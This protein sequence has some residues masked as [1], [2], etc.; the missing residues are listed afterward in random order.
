[1]RWHRFA[2]LYFAIPLFMSV[3]LA[4][5]GSAYAPRNNAVGAFMLVATFCLPYYWMNAGFTYSAL[6]LLRRVGWP[7]YLALVFG[8]AAGT[9]AGYFYFVGYINMMSDVF[10][11]LKN[12]LSPDRT[13]L[14][15]GFASYISGPPGYIYVPIWVALHAAYESA[16][17]DWIFFPQFCQQD[18][19]VGKQD[20]LPAGLPLFLVRVPS[21]IRDSILALEAD[22]HYVNVYGKQGTCKVLYR[23]GD[24][25]LELDSL[26]IGLRVHRSYWVASSAI[27]EL[28]QREKRLFIKLSNDMCVPVSHANSGAVRRLAQSISSTMKPSRLAHR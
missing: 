9:L 14:L 7:P 23:F 3:Y 16:T 22:E 28:E 5:H 6:L 12:G 17:R 8:G 4:S 25:V 1:M 15:G 18:A 24:A 27:V 10:P 11:S 21:H 2:I 13:G 19:D 26:N 20:N